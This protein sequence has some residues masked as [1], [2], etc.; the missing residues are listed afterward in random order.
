MTQR[1]EVYEDLLRALQV[2]NIINEQTPIPNIFYAMWLLENRQLGLSVNIKVNSNFLKHTEKLILLF[3][4]E[5]SK[6]FCP[7]C[8]S[9]ATIIREQSGSLL[10][11]KRI[12]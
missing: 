10:D 5:D 11:I 7:H 2:I 9:I 3:F 8:R 1:S 4:L 6:P 12:L